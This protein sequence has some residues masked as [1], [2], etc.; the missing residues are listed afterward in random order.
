[1][2]Q[3]LRILLVCQNLDL[4]YVGNII[5]EHLLTYDLCI[6]MECGK[7]NPISNPLDNSYVFYLFWYNP[8]DLDQISSP[9]ASFSFSLN[10][11]L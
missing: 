3:D 5:F 2:V 4:I 11:F 8:H 1:M 10:F 7:E 6:D 9:N